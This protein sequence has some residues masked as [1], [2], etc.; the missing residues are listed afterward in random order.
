M[1]APAII[2]TFDISLLASGYCHD[3]LHQWRE[4]GLLEQV[5]E[6]GPYIIITH[7]S[8]GQL[9]AQLFCLVDPHGQQ[10]WVL[11]ILVTPEW[12]WLGLHA[13]QA[14]APGNTSPLATGMMAHRSLH[15]DDEWMV[16]LRALS[17]HVGSTK[18]PLALAQPSMAVDT[19]A[20]PA[21]VPVLIP[22]ALRDVPEITMADFVPQVAPP[23]PPPP[24]VIDPHYGGG[25]QITGRDGKEVPRKYWRY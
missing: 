1:S 25:V 7:S 2:T 4:A 15:F 23:P 10:P 20:M 22:P 17:A 21:D 24:P 13:I 8:L 6:Q 5:L 12:L 9:G 18:G 14:S 19:P 11:R 3:N 16:L